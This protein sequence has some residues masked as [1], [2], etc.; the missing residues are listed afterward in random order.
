ML[1]RR[2][3][4]LDAV[5][6]GG[7]AL[8][9]AGL[10]LHFW[11]AQDADSTYFARIH[12]ATYGRPAPRV[13]VDEGHWNVHTASGRYRPFVH[14]L[15]RDGYRVSSNKQRFVAGLFDGFHVL[16]I[17]NALGFKGSLQHLANLAGLEGRVHF[18]A[19][20]FEPAEITLVRDWVRSGG[21]LLLV[22]DH[23]PCGRA[24]RAMAAAFG[25]EMTDWY[26]EDPG[27]AVRFEPGRGLREHPI[28]RGRPG[29]NERVDLVETYTGQ[30]LIA[31]S[32]AAL[33]VLSDRAREYPRR[34]SASAEARSAAGKAQ[35][36]ALEFGHGRVVVM[37]EAAALTAQR[38]RRNGVEV[39]YGINSGE[40]DNQQLVLNVMHWLTRTL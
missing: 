40:T 11:P 31:P 25:V 34:Q 24:A 35:G 32:A 39:R 16:V 17:A 7:L 14:L 30:S 23:S 13:L 20:A 36:V 27:P 28:A 15:D 33:L 5:M 1:M 8:A 4:P 12:R 19:E 3:T 18:D 29:L 2:L 37:G 9:A 38:T 6:W 10:A 22:A 21:S 26:V